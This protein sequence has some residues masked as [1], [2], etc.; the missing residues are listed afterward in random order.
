MNRAARMARRQRASIFPP[1]LIGSLQQ[2][3]CEFEYAMFL[4]GRKCWVGPCRSRGLAEQLLVHFG[5][6]WGFGVD[7][8]GTVHHGAIASLLGPELGDFRVYVGMHR[9]VVVVPE[10]LL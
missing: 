9:Q 1:G 6:T 2:A 8:V 7:L 3:V 10:Y 4:A 5:P